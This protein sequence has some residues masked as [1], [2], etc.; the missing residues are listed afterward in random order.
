MVWDVRKK[1]MMEQFV[2]GLMTGLDPKRQQI[3]K[4]L[5]EAHE[6]GIKEMVRE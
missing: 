6:R 4:S 2:E 5:H 3:N 1:Q